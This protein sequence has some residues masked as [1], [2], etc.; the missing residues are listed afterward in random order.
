[1][2]ISEKIRA[3]FIKYKSRGGYVLTLL[4]AAVLAFLAIRGAN[5]QEMLEILRK[6]RVEYLILGCSVGTGSYF[7]RALRWRL[8]LLS[9]KR[10]SPLTVFWGAMAGYL[11]NS[12]L[13]ARAGE[14]VRT[15]LL[16]RHSG[17]KVSFVL[18]TALTERVV[19]FVVLAGIAWAAIIWLGVLPSWLATALGIIGPVALGGLVLLIALPH[20]GVPF[21]WLLAR[22]R[23]P[24][25][26]R[27]RVVELLEQFLI[28]IRAVQRPSSGLAFIGLTGM[29]WLADALSTILGARALNLTLSLTQA[30]VL[31]AALG[32]SSAIPSAPGYIGTYQFVAVTVM[33]AFGLSQTEALAYIIVAQLCSY[34]VVTLWGLV[35][36]WQLRKVQVEYAA[37]FEQVEIRS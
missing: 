5:W 11:A 4:L 1:M 16:A 23:L 35:G 37:P 30:L 6:T 20:L 2:S 32:L 9:E 34:A 12:Y 28:G 3:S 10:I 17:F 7:I 36:L 33:P 18:A 19:D 26:L 24:D 31:L 22:L 29:V 25:T 8:L 21:K 13:P 15:G 14:L 27:A